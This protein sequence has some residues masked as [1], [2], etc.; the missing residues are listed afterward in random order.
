MGP[1]RDQTGPSISWKL[2]DQQQKSE[3]GQVSDFA[4]SAYK[5]FTN[6]S[7]QCRPRTRTARRTTSMPENSKQRERASKRLMG[8]TSSLTD[9]E[10]VAL[11]NR[12]LQ[13]DAFVKARLVLSNRQNE[14][15]ARGFK[16]C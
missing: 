2:S 16:V 1:R 14:H 4:A 12:R 8:D 11:E 10:T 5:T 3:S 7:V 6:I 15:G 9:L 13:L